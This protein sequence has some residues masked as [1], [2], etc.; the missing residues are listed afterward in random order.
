MNLDPRFIM[1]TTQVVVA[2]NALCVGAVWTNAPDGW[3][4]RARAG[5]LRIHE[6]P[7]R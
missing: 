7:V 6:V 3:P 5:S 4:L 1:E 2:R